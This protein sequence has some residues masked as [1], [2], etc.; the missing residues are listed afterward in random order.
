MKVL[1]LLLSLLLTPGYAASTAVCY[2]TT[3][4]GQLDG[5]ARLPLR[6][7]NFRSYSVLGVGL[8]R[9]FVHPTVAEVVK[10][11][12]ALAAERSPDARFVV[13][14]SG[15]RRGG[16]LPPHRTHANGLSVDFFVPVRDDAGRARRLPTHVG[17]LF[18]YK[19]ELDADAHYRGYVL[20][21]EALA[22]HLVA[23]DEVARSRGIRLKRIIFTPDYHRRLWATSRGAAVKKLPFMANEAWVRHDEHYHVDF[24]IR[25]ERGR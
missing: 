19:L 11:A 9:T 10:A 8:G 7:P 3:S 22:E 2:G 1:I 14:E 17:T 24:D 13:G 18:G 16:P 5:G 23:L 21:F 20:D 15:R 6:G 12:Y 25:C 4:D